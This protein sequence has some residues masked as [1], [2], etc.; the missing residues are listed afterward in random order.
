MFPS[1]LTRNLDLGT[2]QFLLQTR[3]NQ[4]PP[5]DHKSNLINRLGQSGGVHVELSRQLHAVAPVP[6]GRHQGG[7]GLGDEVTD[8][9]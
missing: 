2:Q 5:G 9:A 3:R 6:L 7:V 8:A 4:S 1:G